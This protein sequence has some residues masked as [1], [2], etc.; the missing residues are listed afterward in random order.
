MGLYR[1]RIAIVP[2]SK[3]FPCLRLADHN[4]KTNWTT[5][6]LSLEIRE[7]G[8]GRAES[9]ANFHAGLALGNEARTRVDHVCISRRKN[10]GRAG[11]ARSRR[12]LVVVGG[13]LGGARVEGVAGE[14]EVTA[15]VVQEWRERF[16]MAR[17]EELERARLVET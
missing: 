6:A 1:N 5:S 12:R 16:S 11:R 8:I 3:I 17:E 10:G 2:F 14:G 7:I 13:L 9:T 15:A 4:I